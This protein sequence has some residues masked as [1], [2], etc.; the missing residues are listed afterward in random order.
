MFNWP[1]SKRSATLKSK[2]SARELPHIDIDFSLFSTNNEYIKVWLP[3]KLIIVLNNL[4]VMYGSSRPDI[5]K[6]LLFHHVYGIAAFETFVSWKKAR[7]DGLAA[8]DEA[9]SNVKLSPQRTDSIEYIGK[10]TENLKVWLPSLLK[11]DVTELAAAY[12][13]GVSDYV[14]MV[15]VRSLLGE[16]FYTGWQ[17]YIGVVPA[18]AILDEKD[19]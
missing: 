2:A 3:H 4:S 6:T 18:E 12:D 1:F 15:L 16:R 19:V 11:T 9:G 14:R 5:I 7:D 17:R 10:S 13:L 8:S